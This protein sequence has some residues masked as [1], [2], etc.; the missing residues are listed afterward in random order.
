MPEHKEA[1]N[2]VFNNHV[3]MLRIRSEHAIGALKGCFQSLKGIRV[4]IVDE[5][6]HRFATYWGVAGITLHAFAMKCEAEERR[7][8]RSNDEA[9]TGDD[10][11]QDPFI[12]EGHS[13]DSSSDLHPGQEP[14]QGSRAFQRL[15]S[16]KQKR[17]NL[18]AALFRHKAHQARRQ[19]QR[20]GQTSDTD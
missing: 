5:R 15:H 10:V 12:D 13:S 11:L 8:A 17:E 16:G 3:S 14:R 18:K 1:D 2:E 6:S 7:A 20:L 19:E 9:S 4:R